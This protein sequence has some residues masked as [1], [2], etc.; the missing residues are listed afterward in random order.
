V[1]APADFATIYGLD[2]LYAANAAGA[3]QSIAIVGQSDFNDADIAA[4]RAQFSLTPNPPQRVLVPGT[5]QATQ[6]PSDLAETELDLEWAG[7]VARESTVTLVFAG[8]APNADVYDALIYAVEQRIAPVVSISYGR[9]EARFTPTDAVFA[10]QYGDAAALEGVTVVAATGDTGAAGCDSQSETVASRGEYVVIPASLPSV[11]A[12][13]GTQFEVTSANQSMYFDGA[14]NALSYVPE[15]AWNETLFDIDA[16]YGGLGSGGGGVSR[17]FAKPDWQVPYTPQDGFRDVPDISLSASSDVLPYAVS[18]SWTVAD[19]DAEATQP[20]SL[21]AFGGTSLSAPAF[22]GMLALVNEAIAESHPGG[23]VGLGNANPMLYAL[24]HS[25]AAENAFHD[26]TAGDNVVPCQP[27]SADC[28]AIAPHLFGYSAGPGYD[29][30][31]GL[32]SVDVAKLVAAWRELTPTS[33]TLQV[34]ETG[35]T[36]GSP[37]R[38]TATIL[39]SAI[40]NKMTGSVTF[41]FETPA[42]AGVSLSGMLGTVSVAPSFSTSEVGVALLTTSAPAGLN[43]SGVKISAFYGGDANYLASW[44]AP[45]PTSGTSTF[46]V[47]PSAL[48]ISSGQNFV[49]TST[50][51]KG[52]IAWTIQSD[53]TCDETKCSGID[54]GA[55]VAGPRA[56]SATVVAIDAYESYV[57]AAVT[58]TEAGAESAVASLPCG[59]DGGPGPA[60]DDS[61]ASAAADAQADGT[62]ADGLD[63]GQRLRE[64]SSHN[65]GCGCAT[66]GFELQD[67]SVG[68]AGVAILAAVAL[69]RRRKSEKAPSS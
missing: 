9:C 16:G 59:S 36:E 22:A 54:A 7:A 14:F 23:L 28:P 6:T 63:A 1:L 5:G 65:G 61:G 41:Y 20:E 66:V 10:E 3:G 37:L 19:G 51:G 46:T 18:M 56:G 62:L 45:S 15:S 27:G 42:D 53:T 24:A 39:S 49:F 67:E 29:L 34:E 64:S 47:C 69:A 32:G 40:T 30:A 58:V 26:V 12:V 17:I 13:G 8:G 33:T 50:G 68:L 44:S 35:T 55:F 57:T 11:V 52:P 21:T 25:P 38:L 60:L 31:T 43:G 2:T 4:F 48:S